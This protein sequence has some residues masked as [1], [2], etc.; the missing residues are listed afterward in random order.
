MTT[1]SF[2]QAKD[3]E[4]VFHAK[5]SAAFIIR[6]SVVEMQSVQRLMRN[7]GLLESVID[8]CGTSEGVK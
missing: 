2:L 7:I 6:M 3:L 1:D 8:N 5:I 4:L